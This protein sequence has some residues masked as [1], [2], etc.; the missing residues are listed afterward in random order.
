MGYMSITAGTAPARART[1]RLMRRAVEVPVLA[2]LR[3][4]HDGTLIVPRKLYWSG[5]EQCGSVDLR[6]EDEVAL[7]YESVIDAA[8]TTADLTENL[9]AGLLVRVWPTLGIALA[10]REAWEARNPELALARALPAAVAV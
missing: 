3:G 7:A 1:P 5:G 4:P 8:R 10:R 9:N 2:E 6:N